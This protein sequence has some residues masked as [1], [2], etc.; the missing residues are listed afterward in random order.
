VFHSGVSP[1]FAHSLYTVVVPA[2]T[3][4]DVKTCLRSSLSLHAGKCVFQHPQS[5]GLAV[6]DI[7]AQR[8]RSLDHLSVALTFE[9][10]SPK[11]TAGPR[12][13][14]VSRAGCLGTRL[15]LNTVDENGISLREDP[16]T[17]SL[18]SALP[19]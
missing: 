12:P 13:P 19:H 10:R 7:K 6:R 8:K 14:R 1:G 3:A 16:M 18:G 11:T 17:A 2:A 5:G 9:A 15:R 4:N